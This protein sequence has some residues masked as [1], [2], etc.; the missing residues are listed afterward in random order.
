MN[1]THVLELI[2]QSLIITI[3]SIYYIFIYLFE[4]SVILK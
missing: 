3:N 1:D 2:K 4:V